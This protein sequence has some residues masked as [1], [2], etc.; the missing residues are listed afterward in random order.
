[1]ILLGWSQP[2]PDAAV[3]AIQVGTLKV[4]RVAFRGNDWELLQGFYYEQG[5]KKEF[6]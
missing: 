3:K 1:M 6:Q 2:L 4:I 5:V